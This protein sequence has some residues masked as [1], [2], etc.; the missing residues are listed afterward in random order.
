[1]AKPLLFAFIEIETIEKVALSEIENLKP[2][3]MASL[4][5]FLASSQS[6]N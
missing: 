5:C 3:S 1:L 6:M 2:H 4:I